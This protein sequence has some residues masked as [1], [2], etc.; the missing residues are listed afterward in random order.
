[1]TK[2]SPSATIALRSVS[3]RK[4]YFCEVKSPLPYVAYISAPD[5]I[6]LV[7]KMI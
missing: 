2:S 7:D 6:I 4:G 3:I 5:S 1:M